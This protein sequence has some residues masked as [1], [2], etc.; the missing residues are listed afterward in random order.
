MDFQE[1]YNYLKYKEIISYSNATDA[2]IDNISNL[3]KKEI[4]KEFTA[5][6][7]PN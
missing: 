3:V 6:R 4:Q 1:L 7:K 2:E 5:Q